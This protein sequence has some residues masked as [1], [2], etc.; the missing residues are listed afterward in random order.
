VSHYFIRPDEN[1]Y[2]IWAFYDDG[3]EEAHVTGM[4]REAAERTLELAGQPIRYDDRQL[5]LDL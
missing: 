4:T 5:K 1:G 3:T 2:S